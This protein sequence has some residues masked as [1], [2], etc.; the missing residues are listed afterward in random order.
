VCTAVKQRH[1]DG[2]GVDAGQ[3]V[4]AA[5]V[6]RDGPGLPQPHTTAVNELEMTQ[7]AVRVAVAAEADAARCS[8]AWLG[9]RA[10]FRHKIPC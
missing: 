10:G 7:S 9:H 6:R 2:A 1:G 8:M 4:G 3:P 5:G